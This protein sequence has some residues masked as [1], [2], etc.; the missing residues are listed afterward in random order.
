M[1]MSNMIDGMKDDKVGL[2]V[3]A[4]Q[5]FTQIPIT[6]DYVSAKMF[7]ETISPSM[8]TVQGTDIAEAIRL[9][10]KSFTKQDGVAKAIFL[11][12]DGEDN[13]G[14]AVEAAKNA[15]AINLTEEQ[16]AKIS[17]LSLEEIERIKK[18]TVAE[19]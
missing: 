9:G 14:G 11:I 10:C 12:T 6:S 8:I 19:N 16:A 3:Y 17:G 2:I 5:A 4:G 13:E 18:E 1:M 7:L 15:L